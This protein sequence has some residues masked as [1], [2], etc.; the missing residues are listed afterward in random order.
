MN[1]CPTLLF[2]VLDFKSV[3]A[4]YASGKSPV[5]LV[6]EI[7]RRI[8][9]RGADHV[10]IHLPS[11]DQ[12]LETLPSDST[13][14]LFGV[15]FAVKD[16]IDVQGW[17][18]TAGCEEFSYIPKDDATVV[19][20]LREAGAI[21][22]GKTNLDQFATGLVGTRSPFGIP[23]SVFDENVISGGSSSGSAVAVAA[24]LVSFALGT[25]TAG[26]GRVPAAF[27][28]VIGLKP[29]RGLLG[30]GGVVP[31]C[32]SLDCVSVFSSQVADSTEV[33]RIARGFD[34][35]DSFSRSL[36][37]SNSFP[38]EKLRIGVPP[39]NQLEF[40]GDHEAAH[41]FQE[42]VA[43]FIQQGHTVISIDFAPFQETARL[44]YS[45]PW[46]A[47]RLA[48]IKPFFDKHA[49]ALHPVTRQIIG[50][51]TRFNAVETFQGFYELERLRRLADLEWAKMDALLLPTT[52]TIYTV[53]QLLADPVGLNTNLGYYTN[54]VNLLDLCGIAVPAGIRSGLPFGITLLA[55]AFY[56]EAISRLGAEFL[57][58]SSLPVKE[59][60]VLLAVV[61][62]HLSGQPLN[63]QLTDQGGRLVRTCRSAAHYRLLALANTTPPKPGLVRVPGVNGPG[64]E[65]EVWRLS[66]Q[67]FGKF[68]EQVPQPMVIGTVDLEDG[69][70]CKGFSC[71]PCACEG[72][73]DITE[74]GG[75]RNYLSNQ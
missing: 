3:R 61:G 19:R 67:G 63:H 9:E 49:D 43:R 29:T 27:N 7:Y 6:R 1:A 26:S 14:P 53:E 55:P 32:R 56:D 24:G 69:T 45:G 42:A 74:F 70:R 28:G 52:G 60:G 75:W 11:L 47:E 54:F 50:A 23:R 66:P 34:G 51:A 10:W 40:F 68:V 38:D 31:A 35:S 48:A 71:E 18:T 21:P 39:A 36:Q 25:D 72:A 22:I 12:L 33:F 46:V 58:E 65:L 5:D 8:A 37:I 44:L 16:N 57:G 59:E 15:P 2:P 4:F 73:T 17:P 20:K 64:I 30:L 41:L 13:L 62:A